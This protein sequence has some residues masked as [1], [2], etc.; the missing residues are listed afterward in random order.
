MLNNYVVAALFQNLGPGLMVLGGLTKGFVRGGV[1]LVV[2]LPS[3]VLDVL[4]KYLVALRNYEHRIHAKRSNTFVVVFARGLGRNALC[5][6]VLARGAIRS[7]T[8]EGHCAFCFRF[9][10]GFRCPRASEVGVRVRF[11]MLALLFRNLSF[12]RAPRFQ[13]G[14]FLR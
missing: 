14:Y 12:Y 2:Y 11:L 1:F 5:K 4:R 7:A 6:D 3:G 10:L 8:N 13:G 9:A